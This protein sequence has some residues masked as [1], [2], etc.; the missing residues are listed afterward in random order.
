VRQILDTVNHLISTVDLRNDQEVIDD[1]AIGDVLAIQKRQPCKLP[2]ITQPA[3]GDD[4]EVSVIRYHDPTERGGAFEEQLVIQALPA[5]LFGCDDLDTTLPEPG[6]NRAG[7]MLVEV[8]RQA[9]A[10][11]FLARSN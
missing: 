11:A 7:N 8:E 5:I 10:R 3:C 2:S 4:K 6:G 9:Q 1:L